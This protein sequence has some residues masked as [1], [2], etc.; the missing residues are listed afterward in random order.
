MRG[1]GCESCHGG[2][3]D[4]I[5]VHYERDVSREHLVQLGMVD[6]KNLF[7]SSA[8]NVA[9]CHVGSAIRT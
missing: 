8:V 3:R 7:V 2:A 5:A 9:A 6:T 4:W 1:I